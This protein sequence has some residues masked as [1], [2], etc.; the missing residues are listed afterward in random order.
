MYTRRIY[1]YIYGK[2][3]KYIWLRGRKI[4]NLHFPVASYVCVLNI[5]ACVCFYVYLPT[6]FTTTCIQNQK[7]YVYAST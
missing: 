7:G 6:H 5:Y 2:Y 3:N 4:I 1:K